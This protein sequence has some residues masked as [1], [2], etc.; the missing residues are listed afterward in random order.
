ML[1]ETHAKKEECKCMEDSCEMGAW[2][3]ELGRD[4]KIATLKKKER[5]LEAKLE[6]I[7][8]IN[9]LIEKSSPEPEEKE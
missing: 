4:F 9:K 7:R 2:A 1:E 3:K 5:I 6:F 8:E